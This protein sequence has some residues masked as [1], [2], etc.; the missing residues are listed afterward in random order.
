MLA[1][2]FLTASLASVAFVTS[3]DPDLDFSWMEGCWQADEGRTK[4]VWSEDFGGVRFGYAATLNEEGKA[5]FYEQMV[6]HETEQGWAFT[7]LTRA[8]GV[9]VTFPLTRVG[10]TDATFENPDHDFPQKIYYYLVE[11]QLHADVT[12]LS[13]DNGFTAKLV[14]CR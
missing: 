5:G 10:D 1:T 4:E 2:F 9:P 3:A 14:P 6:I 11:A 8:N 13:G 7:A 12:D